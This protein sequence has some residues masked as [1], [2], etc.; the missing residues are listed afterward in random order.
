MTYLS[1]V[2]EMVRILAVAMLWG[3]GVAVVSG[4]FYRRAR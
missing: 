1:L 2:L 3:A 4:M